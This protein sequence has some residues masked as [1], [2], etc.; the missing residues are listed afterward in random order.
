MKPI[1]PFS[2][3]P[4]IR[5]R[6]CSFFAD[7]PEVGRHVQNIGAA[8]HYHLVDYPDEFDAESESLVDALYKWIRRT[9]G[10][11][12]E[13]L[14]DGDGRCTDDRGEV[15]ENPGELVISGAQQLAAYALWLLDVEMPPLVGQHADEWDERQKALHGWT[16]TQVRD[17]RVSIMLF[18]FS[19]LSFACEINRYS[20]FGKAGAKKRHAGMEKLRTFAVSQYRRRTWPSANKA[21][22]DLAAEVRQF[23]IENGLMPL[24]L[25]NA[26]RTLAEW[27][28]K[29]ESG[30]A[31]AS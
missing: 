8:L 7:T 1:D 11:S 10:M 16:A 30:Q 19:A 13:W 29:A 2:L 21:A 31:A 25:E 24:S 15:V 6:L 3:L 28:R 9:G 26:Q 5:A 20:E 14:I 12:Q 22:H 27:F 17:N 18:A 4:S 23:A